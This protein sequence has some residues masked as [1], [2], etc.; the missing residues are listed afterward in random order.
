MTAGTAI[1]ATGLDT[2]DAKD[3]SRRLYRETA[4]ERA[5]QPAENIRPAV[6]QHPNIR[7]I[8]EASSRGRP[9]Q[10]HTPED[11]HDHT[12]RTGRQRLAAAR[13]NS[14]TAADRAVRPGSLV[15]RP[16]E[17]L[18]QSSTGRTRRTMRKLSATIDPTVPIADTTRQPAERP[19]RPSERS[20]R[21]EAVLKPVSHVSSPMS[22][23]TY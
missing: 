2:I 8:R 11:A 13:H 6:G 20:G 1:S 14:R 23:P 22:A 5:E 19:D 18:G 9:N 21:P 10:N 4:A 16:A 7:P 15:P 3:W 17:N 12:A